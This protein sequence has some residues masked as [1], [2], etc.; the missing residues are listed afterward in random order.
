MET[1]GILVKLLEV[2]VFTD[3]PKPDINEAEVT[4]QAEQDKSS[5]VSVSPG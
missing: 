4:H 3:N 2:G 5:F 1:E